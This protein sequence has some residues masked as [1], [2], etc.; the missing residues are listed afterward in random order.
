VVFVDNGLFVVSFNIIHGSY[1]IILLYCCWV[2]VKI[3][4]WIV[5]W[6]KTEILYSYY[7]ILYALQYSTI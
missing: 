5:Y 2:A 1:I 4:C 6:R 7:S 3:V